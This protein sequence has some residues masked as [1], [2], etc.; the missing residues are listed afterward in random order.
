MGSRF[1]EPYDIWRD[2]GTDDL[3][4]SDAGQG[5]AIVKFDQATEEFTY[6]PAPRRSDMPKMDVS[7]DGH[8]WYPIRAIPDGAVGVLL[9]D[10]N[11]VT[12]LAAKS[13]AVPD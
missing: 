11:Q 9:P 8:I 2:R 13:Q 3:W 4:I 1:S 6:Y 5:G 7:A 10:K 12:T